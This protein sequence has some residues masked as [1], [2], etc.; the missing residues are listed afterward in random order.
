MAK[1][2]PALNTSSMADISF[3]LL[4]FFLLTSSINTQKGIARKLPPPPQKNEQQVDI[5]KRNILQ[6]WINYKD[7]LYINFE[8]TDISQLKDR[9]KE[10]LSNP[11]NDPEL[12]VIE[13]KDIDGLGK[14]RVSKG[15]ISLKNDRSTSYNI[16]LQV[17]NELTLA[18]NELRD[19]LAMERFQKKFDKLGE[20]KRKAIAKA[21]PISISEAEPENVGGNK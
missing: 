18:I 11:N 16:Y 19:E 17:Q 8:P 9:A 3:L 10:F 7:E 21:I 4:T 15:V 12:P 5:N 13:E 6:V 1:E 14:T 2:T 20:S